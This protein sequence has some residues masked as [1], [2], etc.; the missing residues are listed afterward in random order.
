MTL[1]G[2]PL[3]DIDILVDDLRTLGGKGQRGCVANALA[4]CGD[5]G[6]FSF[7]SHCISMVAACT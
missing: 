6:G 2:A 5:Q 1:E 4:G 3:L 7:E